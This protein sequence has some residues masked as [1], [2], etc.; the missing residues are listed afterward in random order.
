LTNIYNKI[1]EEKVIALYKQGKTRRE[2]AKIVHMSLGDIGDIIKKYIED[3]EIQKN[4]LR[5]SDI[6]EETK[7]M[8]LFS[9]GKPPI[10]VKIE[11]NVST[12]KWKNFIRI[13]GD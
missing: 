3:E 12:E 7:A 2:I 1:K 11:L 9:Q 4:N 6:S 5:N 8:Q 13:I 10:E